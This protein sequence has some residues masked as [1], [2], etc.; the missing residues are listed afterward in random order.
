M[1]VVIKW[2]GYHAG[3]YFLSRLLRYVLIPRNRMECKGHMPFTGE[4]LLVMHVM[5]TNEHFT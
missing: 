1:F 5:Y 3:G 2:K 4:V